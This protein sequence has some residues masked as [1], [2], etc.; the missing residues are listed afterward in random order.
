MLRYWRQYSKWIK[1]TEKLLMCLS[2]KR[3]LNCVSP[4]RK[5]TQGWTNFFLG[6][7]LFGAQDKLRAQSGKQL[8]GPLKTEVH[9]LE[10]TRNIAFCSLLPKYPLQ[11][12]FLMCLHL[13]FIQ[14]DFCC[15]NV[16]LTSKIRCASK[17][18]FHNSNFSV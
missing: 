13:K 8:N 2:L 17:N 15:L 11:F 1:S 9:V 3:H 6:A 7:R 18:N 12:S 16:V 10:T 4:W 14:W 5:N